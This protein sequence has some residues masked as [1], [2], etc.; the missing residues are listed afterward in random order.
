MCFLDDLTIKNVIVEGGALRGLIDFDAVC[1]GDPLFWLG[2]TATVLVCDLGPR[3]RFYGDELCRLLALTPDQRRLAWPLYAAW[4]S[5]G[6]L[7]DGS[8]ARGETDDWRAR[9]NAAREAWLA[10]AEE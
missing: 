8:S 5:L 4:I 3:E 10:E 7:R 9:L 6:F 1:Y 2:L